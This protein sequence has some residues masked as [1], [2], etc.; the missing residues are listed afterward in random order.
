MVSATVEKIVFSVSEV[1]EMLDIS[2]R[3]V[4]NMC[5]QHKMPHVRLGTKG[6]RVVIPKKALYEWLE[7]SAN[8]SKRNSP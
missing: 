4:L 2:G 8:S 5:N 1:A 6:D 3:T 7:Q